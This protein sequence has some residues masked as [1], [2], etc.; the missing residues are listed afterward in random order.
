MPLRPLGLQDWALVAS[1]QRAELFAPV[2]RLTATVASASG[3]LALL[4][5][6]L[7]LLL[8]RRYGA[9]LRESQRRLEAS[10]ADLRRMNAELEALSYSF[11][12]ELRS[13]LRAVDGFS[14]ALE[15]DLRGQLSPDARHSL[16]RIRSAAG[17]MAGV[18]DGLLSLSRV[19]RAG[20]AQQEVDLSAVAREE[21]DWLREEAP[22]RPLEFVCSEGLRAL[23]DPRMLRI[24]MRILLENAWKYSRESSPARIEFGSE[25][26]AEGLLFFVRDNGSGFDERFADKLF[27]P[28]QRLHSE[29]EFEGSGIGLATAKRII[30]RHA[31]KI[32]AKGKLGQGACV[33]FHLRQ[34]T[35]GGQH[36]S[37][38]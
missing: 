15:E 32:W 17:R 23:G 16:E 29:S 4:A 37:Q 21:M 12:H 24:L 7:S 26:A 14:H 13:P 5:I 34:E 28:F 27:M 11:S 38:R 33:Y 6:V 18:I 30:E 25:A 35:Q 19:S 3:L 8:D 2:Y 31:G 22:Q 1:I 36:G 20:L 9:P 10:N